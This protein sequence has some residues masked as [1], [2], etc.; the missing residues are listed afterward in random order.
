VFL[1]SSR[2]ATDDRD[3]FDG[4][5]FE[6]P[7]HH[8]RPRPDARDI[9]DSTAGKHPVRL[10]GP[11]P[12]PLPVLPDSGNP[13]AQADHADVLARKAHEVGD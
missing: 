13:A 1:C 10:A 2:F 7:G 3:R 6:Y 4:H 9:S 5:Q 11:G 8:E 12:L